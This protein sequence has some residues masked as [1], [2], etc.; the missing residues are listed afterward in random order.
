MKYDL[1]L[2]LVLKTNKLKGYIQFEFIYLMLGIELKPVSDIGAAAPCFPHVQI[3][4][5]NRLRII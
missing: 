1:V 3:Y 5:E 2:F 4:H